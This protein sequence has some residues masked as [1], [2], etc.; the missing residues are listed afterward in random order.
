M[1]TVG[2][3]FYT[4]SSHATDVSTSPSVSETLLGKLL[5]LKERG[6][7]SEAIALAEIFVQQN[8]FAADFRDLLAEMYLSSGDYNKSLAHAEAS[9]R[10]NI[11]NHR[12]QEATA[13]V[14]LRQKKWQDF[15]SFTEKLG[16]PT[17]PIL[18]LKARALLNTDQ[19]SEAKKIVAEH[20]AVLLKDFEYYELLGE[21]ETKSKNFIAA[22]KNYRVAFEMNSSSAE[23]QYKMGKSLTELKRF[24]EA[25]KIFAYLATQYTACNGCR[26]QYLS[27]LA[28]QDRWDLVGA[29]LSQWHQ[30]EPRSEWLALSYARLL[31]FVGDKDLA[32]KIIDTHLKASPVTSHALDLKFS[33][34]SWVSAANKK[35]RQPANSE[36]LYRVQEADTIS[37]ISKRIYGSARFAPQILKANPSLDPLKLKLGAKLVLPDSIVAHILNPPVLVDSKSLWVAEILGSEP[38]LEGTWMK[39]TARKPAFSDVD[40][41]MTDSAK[42]LFPR[43]YLEF[44][45]GPLSQSF[46]MESPTLS[47]NLA[48]QTGLQVSVLGSYQFSNSSFF[49][50]SELVYQQAS[51]EG[52]VG[53]SPNSLDVKQHALRVLPGYTLWEHEKSRFDVLVGWGYH[54]R[55]LQQT[56]PNVV[57]SSYENHGPVVGI[58]GNWAASS[59][60]SVFGSGS[61]STVTGHNEKSVR[62][63]VFLEGQRLNLGA[64]L[65]YAVGQD[66]EVFA[67][68]QYSAE[69]IQFSGSDQ[70]GLQ[71]IKERADAIAFPLGFRTRF[72]K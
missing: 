46:V 17:G 18:I 28:K 24:E 47:A 19:V 70:R 3:S 21:L 30:E 54:D 37:G 61:F 67:G 42:S 5:V 25:E 41:E 55:I 53:Y 26:Y 31:L 23:L 8:P 33:L 48:K 1:I 4:L 2:T 44:S 15:F 64:G 10:M 66:Y 13:K 62:S 65:S 71:N 16:T 11:N 43:T 7:T 9:F 58:N 50:Q 39:R 69:Q 60:F 36:T 6:Q 63:G 29:L 12:A 38:A 22:Y 68:V 52:I 35:A 34:E 51:Y 72:G 14:L 20:E 45:S 40:K 56:S 27:A 32:V 49:L 59:R 57:L